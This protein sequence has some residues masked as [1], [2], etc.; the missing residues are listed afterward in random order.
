ML[1]LRFR[2]TWKSTIT[3]DSCYLWLCEVKLVK[4][5]AE[6]SII[7]CLSLQYVLR[8][9]SRREGEGVYKYWNFFV[10]KSN[11]FKLFVRMGMDN[12]YCPYLLQLIILVEIWRRHW[13]SRN[14][15]L[16]HEFLSKPNLR[17]P[18]VD[19]ISCKS[20]RAAVSSNLIILWAVKTKDLWLKCRINAVSF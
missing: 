4:L 8:V 17:R 1:A 16:P 2:K 19:K 14:A 6:F 7:F 15:L 11:Y 10:L 9:V 3:L 12:G 18:W 20:E 13:N 5:L